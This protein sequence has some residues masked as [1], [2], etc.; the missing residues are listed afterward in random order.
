MTPAC[1]DPAGTVGFF[2]CRAGQHLRAAAIDSPRLEARLLL[3]HALGC[4]QEDLLRDPRAAVPPGAAARFGDLLRRR[5]DHAPVAHLLGCQEFWSLPFA[6]SPATLIPR[7]DSEAL[8]EAALEAFPDRGAVRRVLD[9]GTGTGCLL[10]AA[11]SEFPAATG[12]GLD[13]VPA[14][15]AL[16]RANAARLGLGGRA[17]FAVADWAAPVAG[18][19]DLVLSNPPYIESAA[20]PGL[21]PEVAR[22][23]PASALDGGADGLEAYRAIAAALPGLLAPGG[24]AVLELGQGQEEAV[25][26]LAAAAGLR[27]LACRPDL[28]GIPRALVLGAA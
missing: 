10:L 3:A 4:R 18:R 27:C 25:T 23:E 1:A 8:V 6:V 26:A 21:M 12:L 15:A 11:L 20:I 14:A 17:A 9:L 19:F 16:A 13:R 5:L 2:L 28:G 22:H 7:A 24:R